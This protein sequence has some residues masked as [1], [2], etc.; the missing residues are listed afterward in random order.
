MRTVYDLF[1][2]WCVY[3]QR[4][5]KASPNFAVCSKINRFYDRNVFMRKNKQNFLLH[6]I[7]N[8]ERMCSH[9]FSRLLRKGYVF[10]AYL[11]CIYVLFFIT[12]YLQNR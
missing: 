2:E 12:S 11:V 3:S 6:L 9:A 8:T 5:F 1:V 4:R 10:R 7:T